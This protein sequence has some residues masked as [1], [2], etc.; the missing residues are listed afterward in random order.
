MSEALGQY[1]VQKKRRS[2]SRSL[3]GTM[4]D[5][6]L[7]RNKC[8]EHKVVSVKEQEQAAG[9]RIREKGTAGGA[10]RNG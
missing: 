2:K 8:K 9:A 1:P 10:V 6:I 5:K 3:K 4:G 7:T